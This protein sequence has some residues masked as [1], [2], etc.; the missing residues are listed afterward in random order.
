[1]LTKFEHLKFREANTPYDSSCKLIKNS[2]RVVAQLE[3]A[4]AIGT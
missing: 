3:Y 2:G 4:S 1:M